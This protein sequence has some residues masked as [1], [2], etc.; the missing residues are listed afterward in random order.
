MVKPRF[1]VPDRCLKRATLRL[2]RIHRTASAREALRLNE[3]FF[4][5]LAKCSYDCV[6]LSGI[7]LGSAMEDKSGKYH[8][9]TTIARVP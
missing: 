2:T 4:F 9:M 6:N 3:S 5:D 7:S 8:Q 1:V